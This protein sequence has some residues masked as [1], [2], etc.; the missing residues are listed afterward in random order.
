MKLTKTRI[1]AAVAT[2]AIAVAL[3]IAA[4]AAFGPDRQTYVCGQAGICQGADHVQFDSFTNNP[5]YDQHDERN[6]LTIRPAAGGAYTDV[7][8]LTVGQEYVVRAYVHN[9]ADPA[10]T[11]TPSDYTAENTAF[12]VAIPSEVNG[13]ALVTGTISASNAQPGSVYDTV[14]LKS[15]EKLKLNYVAGSAKWTSNGASNGAALSDN[16]LTSG[17][18]LGYDSLNGELPGCFG[19]S[20]YVSLKVKAEKIETPVTPPVTTTP[21]AL[22]QTGAEAAGLAGVAGTGVVGYA[23]MAYRRSKRALA[24]AIR[25]K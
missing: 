14:S 7:Q 5:S 3:P 6:F 12:K 24:T 20:G 8:T 1:A 9:N 17:A 18:L 19:F 25:N 21:T 13:D 10:L 11:N 2:S 22:P 16:V 23:A 4:L 15:G